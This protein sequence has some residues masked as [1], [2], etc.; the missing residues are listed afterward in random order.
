M[1]DSAK[2]D[3]LGGHTSCAQATRAWYTTDTSLKCAA[4]VSAYSVL[5]I[6]NL[7]VLYE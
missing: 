2:P 1:I 7:F 4:E 5:T 6:G 3:S